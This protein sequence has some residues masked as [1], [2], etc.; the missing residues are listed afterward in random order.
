MSFATH[1]LVTTDLSEA[2]EAAVAKTCELTRP[3]DAH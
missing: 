2:S 1:I 3:A